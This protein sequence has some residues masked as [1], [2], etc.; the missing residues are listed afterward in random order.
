[1]L[2]QRLRKMT[3][4]D[5]ARQS[6]EYS[7]FKRTYKLGAELG[8]GGFGTVYSGFRQADGR[9]VAIKFVSKPNVTAWNTLDNRQVPVEIV[10]LE[11]CQDVGGVI[12]ML[13]WYERTD[14][15]V[16]V[17]ERPSP[18]TDLF[19]YIS[20]HGPLHEGVARNF[21]KQVVETM[22]ACSRNGVLH[23]DIKDENLVV[24]LKTA[25][26]KL[27][28]FGSGAFAKAGCYTDFEGT[29][30]YSPPEWI[31]ESRYDGIQATVWSLGILL[32]DMVCGDIPFR[33]DADIIGG[34]IHWRHPIS[35]A[36]KDLIRKCLAIEGPS[37]P[38]LEALLEHPWMQPGEPGK[39]ISTH[40][41]NGAR[42][43]LASVPD[44][45]AHQAAHQRKPRQPQHG[46]EHSTGTTS[47]QPIDVEEPRRD[48]E[49]DLTITR[50]NQEE[51]QPMNI[52]K[53]NVEPCSLAHYSTSPV[54]RKS[55]QTRAQYL[56]AQQRSQPRPL[57]HHHHHPHHH[58]TGSV[59]SNL[60][61]VSVLSSG[62]S[63][64]GTCSTSP[65]TS[66]SGATQGALILGSY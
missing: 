63:G 31:Q 32:Y 9:P 41:L 46:S 16:I 60:C 27:I 7:H 59:G 56:A 38:S 19:D 55:E 57:P 20:D 23:R 65:P 43:K 24:D 11:R 2:K 12:Q 6:H 35:D 51:A 64:Y 21:F 1:M 13:D 42:H 14:G 53:K 25:Q 49:R 47:S 50:G 36:C 39:P 26:L 30:V 17:M 52:D 4:G 44:R 45:L 33:R 37:R 62:S 3:I 29:R 22:M 34:S 48:E 8:R 28:D 18:C 40:E 58:R 54:K 10:L 66:G 15:F 5:V 61:A